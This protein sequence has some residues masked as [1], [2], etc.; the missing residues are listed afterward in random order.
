MCFVYRSVLRQPFKKSQSDLAKS[1]RNRRYPAMCSMQQTGSY[2]NEKK[3][4]KMPEIKPY[5]AKSS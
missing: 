3:E 5:V 2:P 4:L 1:D